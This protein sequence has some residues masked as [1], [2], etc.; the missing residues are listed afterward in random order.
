MS[1]TA[2]DLLKIAENELGYKE[3]P[4]NSNKTK[5]GAWYGLNGQPWCMMFVMWCFAQA[6]VSLP[7]KTASCTV[8]KNAA[9]KAGM[10]VTSGYQAGDVVIYDWTGNG[11]MDHCGIIE[12]FSG[13]SVVAIEGNTA[14]GNDS[15]GGE[16]MRRTRKVGQVAGAVR[17]K[18]AEESKEED[19]VVRYK[20]LSDIPETF[21][22]V[23]EKLMS[24]GIILGSDPNGENAVI[25]LSH[26]QVRILVF[27]YRG[28]AFDRKLEAAG[29][30]PQVK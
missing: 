14:V 29:L 30:D 25:D 1:G 22:P 28:G 2:K 17:P 8:L 21:R 15:D 23:I 7:A 13:S 26:D 3:S 11:V 24:A 12:S 20:H 5:Y 6:E 16:V 10:W 4:T 18:F 27:A 9:K 19:S